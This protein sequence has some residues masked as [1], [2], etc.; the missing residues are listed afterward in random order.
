MVVFIPLTKVGRKDL[1]PII[2]VVLILFVSIACAN[3]LIPSYATIQ[4]EFNIPVAL[5]AIPA[6]TTKYIFPYNI[7]SH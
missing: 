4:Q 6:F 7:N 2:L 5:I 3:M 1:V